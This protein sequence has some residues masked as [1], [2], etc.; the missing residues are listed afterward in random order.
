V[1]IRYQADADLK[2]SIVMGTLRREPAIDFQT[3]RRAGLAGLSDAEVLELAAKEGRIVVSHDRKTMPRH[4]AAF[5]AAGNS[6]PGLFL[7]QQD[8][9]LRRVIDALVL[10]WAASEPREWEN[11]IQDI[12]FR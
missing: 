7:V 6:S 9:D 1:S 3:A 11:T 2:I 12:P 8:A 10:I 5:V 4:F